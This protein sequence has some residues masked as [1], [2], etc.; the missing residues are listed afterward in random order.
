[1][2]LPRLRLERHLGRGRDTR[3]PPGVSCSLSSGQSAGRA[4]PGHVVPPPGWHSRPQL[5]P[6]LISSS[7]PSPASLSILGSTRSHCFLPSAWRPSPPG[8][9]TGSTTSCGSHCSSASPGAPP[10][11]P[12][13]LSGLWV[14]LAL[15]QSLH[16]VTCKTDTMMV[17]HTPG[18]GED[19]MDETVNSSHSHLAE[20]P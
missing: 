16:V 6:H 13:V 14:P 19:W 9:A 10:V 2:V 17:P 15:S 8:L 20:A 3:A 11:S 4:G 18:G 1:M 7:P 12:G 5:S